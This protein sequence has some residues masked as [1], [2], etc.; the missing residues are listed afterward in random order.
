MTTN[1]DKIK[2]S[3]ENP[4]DGD[5]VVITLAELLDSGIPIDEDGNEMEF[6]A[7]EIV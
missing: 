4:Q 5:H 1:P 6:V 3:F 7:A 2:I